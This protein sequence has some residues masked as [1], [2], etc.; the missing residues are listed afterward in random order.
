MS[1]TSCQLCALCLCHAAPKTSNGTATPPLPQCRPARADSTAECPLA[2][3]H[4]TAAARPGTPAKMMRCFLVSVK[5][6]GT[7]RGARI[8]DSR[9]APSTGIP[10]E[11]TR[12]L[13]STVIT[14]VDH[15][16]LAVSIASERAMLVFFWGNHGMGVW[17]TALT[18]LPLFLSGILPAILQTLVSCLQLRRRR[19]CRHAT[20][21]RSPIRR[22]AD[23]LPF[24]CPSCTL[25]RRAV[26]WL[27]QR[28]RC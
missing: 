25:R 2:Q 1:I 11:V 28:E 21:G 15:V 9:G 27:R 19:R 26:P 8:A 23:L 22:A 5:Q 12:T 6:P 7:S 4:L 24:R 20:A 18:L 16:V 17:G 13:E 3:A 10:G 14:Y